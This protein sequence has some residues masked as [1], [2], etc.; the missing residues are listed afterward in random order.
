MSFFMNS[1]CSSAPSPELPAG[2][3]ATVPLPQNSWAA[4]TAALHV[5]SVAFW[6]LLTL[7]LYLVLCSAC[8]VLR[9]FFQA[10]RV[11]LLIA[12]RE[13]LVPSGLLCLLA[14]GGDT[15][16][17]GWTKAE[18]WAWSRASGLQDSLSSIPTAPCI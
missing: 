7:L 16:C 9:I 18:P 13:Q 11:R 6:T 10:W 5:S 15:W 3:Q 4:V 2:G 1:V 17:T 8:W 12:P 14:G